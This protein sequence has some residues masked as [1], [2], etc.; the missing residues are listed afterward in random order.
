MLHKAVVLLLFAV[1]L[2]E[3]SSECPLNELT[4]VRI[5]GNKTAVI[6]GVSTLQKCQDF[7]VS[8]KDTHSA[9]SFD[10][11]TGKCCAAVKDTVYQYQY[12]S[13]WI[14]FEVITRLIFFVPIIF[15]ESGK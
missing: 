14:T 2:E 6:V 11:Q 5:E 4:N 12:G 7:L 3:V 15:E 13:G 9:V 10:K 1:L 8:N